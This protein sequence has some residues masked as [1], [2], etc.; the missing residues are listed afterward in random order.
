M[1]MKRIAFTISVAASVGLV[2][3][4]GGYE[5][6]STTDPVVRDDAAAVARIVEAD[7][8][9]K[10]LSAGGPVARWTCTA[11]LWGRDGAALLAEA[12]CE[13]T[14]RAKRDE[15]GFVS[16]IRVENDQVTYAADGSQFEDSLRRMW[17]PQL[18]EAYLD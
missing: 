17:G 3:A 4:C 18:A 16:P 2:S 7:M 1:T 10:E 11:T 15:A 8:V 9:A 13:A 5:P 14:Y 6:P 12:D